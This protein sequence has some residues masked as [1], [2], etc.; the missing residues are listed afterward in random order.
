ME[1]STT[2]QITTSITSGF[3]DVFVLSH[4][5]KVWLLIG[6]RFIL[7]SMMAVAAMIAVISVYNWI[8]AEGNDLKL[9]ENKAR[10][11][12]AIAMMTLFFVLMAIFHYFVP[13]YSVLAL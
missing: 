8:H 12:N 9:H 6:A 5:S 1:P 3:A 13:D 10:L 7:V 2:Q 4:A 11:G